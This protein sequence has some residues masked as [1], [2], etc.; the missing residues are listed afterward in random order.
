MKKSHA[1][2]GTEDHMAAEVTQRDT[3]LGTAHPSRVS[4][5]NSESG[6]RDI[7]EPSVATPGSIGPM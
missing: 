7:L 1:F 2:Q 3:F 5:F 4:H 6:L